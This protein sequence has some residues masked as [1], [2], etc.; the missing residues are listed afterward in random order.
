MSQ[1][2]PHPSPSFFK[3]FFAYLLLSGI[4]FICGWLWLTQQMESILNQRVS[5]FG[6]TMTRF[7]ADAS[8]ESLVAEDKL[9]LQGLVDSIAQ[10]D[11]IAEAS[12]FRLDGQLL[13]R[14]KTTAESP[15]TEDAPEPTQSS[16]SSDELRTLLTGYLPSFNSSQ[17]PFMENIYWEKTHSGWF[18]V[19]L[20]RQ[21]MEQQLRDRSYHITRM[22]LLGFGITSL[23]VLIIAIHGHYKR[24][25]AYTQPTKVEQVV[26]DKTSTPP[27]SSLAEAAQKIKQSP[28]AIDPD[29]HFKPPRLPAKSLQPPT[30]QERSSS[31]LILRLGGFENDNQTLQEQLQ[32]Q[33]HW[34]QLLSQLSS[35]HGYTLIQQSREEFTVLLPQ[36]DVPASLHFALTLQH[37]VLR[38][39]RHNKTSQV[40]VRGR[41]TQ[42]QYTL[43]Q[44]SGL[45]A[46]DVIT[47][48]LQELS[49][50]TIDELSVGVELETAVKEYLVDADSIDSDNSLPL[51]NNEQRVALDNTEW[52]LVERQ[53]Y[54]LFNQ[55]W[56]ETSTTDE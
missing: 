6:Q 54:T 8:S 56:G 51:T 45:L 40:N 21:F 29:L 31:L 7:A 39:H 4:V 52:S 5:E 42:G 1:P 25:K 47:Q 11:F 24:R 50:Q 18:R 20:N 53:S 33:D 30:L 3:P 19:T 13:A 38:Y 12:V 44:R 28:E 36:Q 48:T 46:G 34:Y 16:E 10:S 23:L 26:A 49:H 55:F 2:Q 9:F 15:T 35:M 32:E 17:V 14:S 41:L 27:T 43:I 37:I 22:T